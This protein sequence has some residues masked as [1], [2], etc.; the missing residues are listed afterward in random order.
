MIEEYKEIFN[1]LRKEL[2]PQYVNDGSRRFISDIIH[3]ELIQ[4]TLE[5][6]LR[7]NTG[8]YTPAPL[9]RSALEIIIL[10]TV[11]NTK[12]SIKYK[13]RK[14]LIENS[15]ILNDILSAADRLKIQFQFGTDCI[16]KLYS[17]GSISTHYALRMK[18]HEIWHS[19]RFIQHLR[20]AGLIIGKD[21][22]AGQIMDSLLDE[23]ISDG[24]IRIK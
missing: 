19:L 8:R 24:K 11:F 16:R 2:D 15:L 5:L 9:I 22:D 17:G 6:L 14:V 12:Y 1:V 23:L 3:N 4:G 13:G 10:R 18:H 20:Y 7:G 21:E